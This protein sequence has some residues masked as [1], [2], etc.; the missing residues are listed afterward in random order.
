MNFDFI[1]IY[2]PDS[3]ST[4]H[5]LTKDDIADIDISLTPFDSIVTSMDIEYDKHPVN[6]KG[7]ESRVEA[8]NSTNITAYNIASNEKKKTVRLDALVS[9]PA[10]SPSSNPNDDYFTYFNNLVSDI[11][12]I[13]SFTVVN[14]IY[15]IMEVGDFV[16]FG[17]VDTNAFASSFSGK[18]FIVT[19]I[20]RKIGTLSVTVRE[21]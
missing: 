21:V 6:G 7:Y 2:I 18:D 15:Y 19:Q 3:I 11:K 14:P 10:S 13:V 20:N 16:A 17:D 8:S 12:T 4:D 5:T 1:F 9:A